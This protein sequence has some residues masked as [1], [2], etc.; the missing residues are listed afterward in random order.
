MKTTIR[1]CAGCG[2]RRQKSEMIRVGAAEGIVAV[3][4][5]GKVPGRGAYVCPDL[6]CLRK[7]KKSGSM[8]RRLRTNVPDALYE[9]LE[10]L[11]RDDQKVTIG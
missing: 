9:E 2:A 3:S 4:A 10:F 5:R 7:A 1:S 6:E 8:S 11:I